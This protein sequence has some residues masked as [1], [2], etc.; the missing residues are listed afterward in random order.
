MI[1]GISPILELEVQLFNI[2]KDHE[3]VVKAA[4]IDGLTV[5][6]NISSIDEE[7]IEDAWLLSDTFR[8]LTTGE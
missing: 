1:E 7:E 6:V 4:F 8:K 5:L 3:R 2:K